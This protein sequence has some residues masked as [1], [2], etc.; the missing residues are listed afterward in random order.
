MKIIFGHEHAAAIFSNKWI[1]VTES[2]PRF[3][4]L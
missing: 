4:D 1:R 3:V 2:P